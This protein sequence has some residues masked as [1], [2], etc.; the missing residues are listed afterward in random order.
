MSELI[1][2][3]KLCDTVLA[4]RNPL[5]AITMAPGQAL[6]FVL[7]APVIATESIPRFANSAM[8]ATHC[9]RGHNDAGATLVV[10]GSTM[11]GEGPGELEQA[12]R[13]GS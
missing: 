7:A 4:R 2:L 12:R 8:T 11:A 9:D 1:D 3:D 6:G 5:D 10:V 13:P